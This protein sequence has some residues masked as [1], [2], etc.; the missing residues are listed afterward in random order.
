MRIRKVDHEYPARYFNSAFTIA[1]Y[2][3]REYLRVGKKTGKL[4]IM[5][6]LYKEQKEREYA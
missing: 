4:E 3:W 5:S 2:Q 1:R 6:V